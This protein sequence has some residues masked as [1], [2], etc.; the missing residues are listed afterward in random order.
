M[1]TFSQPTPSQKALAA[2]PREEDRRRV[3]SDLEQVFKS[4]EGNLLALVVPLH[5]KALNLSYEQMRTATRALWR[6]V[7]VKKCSYVCAHSAQFLKVQEANV[8]I[9]N[10]LPGESIRLKGGKVTANSLVCLKHSQKVQASA[11][12]A[13]TPKAMKPFVSKGDRDESRV[14]VK[15]EDTIA[16]DKPQSQRLSYCLSKGSVDAPARA[17]SLP[18]KDSVNAPTRAYSLPWQG[19]G[20]CPRM[21]S[22]TA[23]PAAALAPAP[24]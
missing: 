1:D 21:G 22:V 24:I 9:A 18:P 15:E 16:L 3:L 19:L 20:H 5:H 17:H 7:S 6:R 2:I 11:K 10:T 13:K 14:Q 12:A 23:P 4:G 8:Q